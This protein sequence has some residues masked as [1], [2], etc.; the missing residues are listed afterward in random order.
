MVSGWNCN[1]SI[2]LALDPDPAAL[3]L[4]KL[5]AEVQ[6]ELGAGLLGGDRRFKLPERLKQFRDVLGFDA[7]AGVEFGAQSSGTSLLLT[8][9]SLKGDVPDGDGIHTKPD[10]NAAGYVTQNGLMLC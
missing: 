4:H 6:S 9:K 3:K 8:S 7:G 1:Y 2:I 10:E 5:L